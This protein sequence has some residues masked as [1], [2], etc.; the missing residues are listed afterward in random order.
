MKRKT[1]EKFA[2]HINRAAD[3][4]DSQTKEH[5]GSYIED[6]T[7]DP[8]DTNAQMQSS[9]NVSLLNQEHHMSG[10]REPIIDG[11]TAKVRLA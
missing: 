10:K 11:K 8:I 9:N 1:N 6:T 4:L 7:M 2:P 3:L 5:G